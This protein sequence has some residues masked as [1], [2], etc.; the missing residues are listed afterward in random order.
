MIGFNAHF[1]YLENNVGIIHTFLLSS[2]LYKVNK[3]E[4]ETTQESI[5]QALNSNSNL[6]LFAITADFYQ[7]HAHPFLEQNKFKKILRFKSAHCDEREILT[8][9][10][11]ENDKA[12]NIKYDKNDPPPSNCSVSFDDKYSHCHSHEISLELLTKERKGYTKIPGI[13]LWYKI[14]PDRLVK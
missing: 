6:A 11:K 2:Y 9:W 3:Q 1:A 5:L 8:L 4:W 7:T 12:Q 10:V 13:N 14:S